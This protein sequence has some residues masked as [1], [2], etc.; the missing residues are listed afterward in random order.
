VQG[1]EK[2]VKWAEEIKSRFFRRIAE[3]RAAEELLL[4]D[5]EVK[6]IRE[7]SDS[8]PATFWIK[9]SAVSAVDLMLYAMEKEM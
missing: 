4:D 8:T 3:L 5:D 9:Y 7:I 1:T 6:E 2:Q